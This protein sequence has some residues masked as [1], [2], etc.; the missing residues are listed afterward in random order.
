MEQTRN[1][2]RLLN[3]QTAPSDTLPPVKF[4]L[5]KFPQ[6]AN[7]GPPGE[8]Q[9]FKH[10]SLW[11]KFQTPIVTCHLYYVPH[12]RVLTVN[13]SLIMHRFFPARFG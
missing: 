6:L 8:G 4:R 1:R 13:Y 12:I 7:T 2:F 5:L 9:M 10:M 11:G 3:I